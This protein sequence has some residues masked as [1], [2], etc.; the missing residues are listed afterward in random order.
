MGAEATVKRAEVRE[1]GGPRSLARLLQLFD[2]LAASPNGMTLADLNLAL[3]TPKSSL[4]NLLRPLVADGYLV[5][6][7]GTYRLGLMIFRLA[8]NVLAAWD[9]T[10]AFRPYVEELAERTGETAMLAVTNRRDRLLNYVDVVHSNQP[11]RYQIPVGTT[12][13]LHVAAAGRVLLAFEDAAYRKAYL[14]GAVLDK[15]MNQP[16]TRK[17]LDRELADIAQAGYAFSLDRFIQG[18]GSIAAPVF[19]ADGK[20]IAALA[21]GG[22]SD[23]TGARVDA[24]IA[25]V[26][27]VAVKA[28]GA[29]IQP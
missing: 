4:L 20:C 6:S 25:I 28:S 29:A 2:V 8:A 1:S 27:E 7:G 17:G 12:R 23:R 11:I 14:G 10:Q 3:D 26:R 16:L 15:G 21:I 24:L 9:V 22:P 5:H 18:L 13:P 19:D